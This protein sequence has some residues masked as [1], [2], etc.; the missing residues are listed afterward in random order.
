MTMHV[1]QF[2]GGIGSWATAMRVAEQHGTADLVLLAA[3]TQ[4]EDPDLWRFVADASA[5]LGVESSPPRRSLSSRGLALLP[6]DNMSAGPRFDRAAISRAVTDRAYVLLRWHRGDG[7]RRG[8]DAAS[9]RRSI[10][11]P[12]CLWR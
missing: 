5:R 8:H 1:V 3:D 9:R 7:G 12:G 6:T 11:G 4:T 10:P 2:S